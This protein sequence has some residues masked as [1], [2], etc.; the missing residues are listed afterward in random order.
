MHPPNPTSTIE[1]LMMATT[2]MTAAVSSCGEVETAACCMGAL[3]RQC[4]ELSCG[5][6]SPH[7]PAGSMKYVASSIVI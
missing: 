7:G 5:I 3:S 4:G 1:I 2:V 6:V